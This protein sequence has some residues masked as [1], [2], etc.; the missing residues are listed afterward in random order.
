MWQAINGTVHLGDWIST[1]ASDMKKRNRYSNI[2]K[3]SRH[4]ANTEAMFF[5]HVVPAD[6]ADLPA[7]RQQHGFDNLDFDFDEHGM[8]FDGKCLAT[9]SLPGY[10]IVSI[11]TGQYIPGAGEI[12]EAPFAYP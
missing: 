2:V 1:N 12:W 3:K 6:V 4:W 5:L 8:L 7:E 11:R 10:P 9:V